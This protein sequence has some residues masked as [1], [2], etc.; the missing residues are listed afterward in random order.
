MGARSTSIA[1]LAASWAVL[2]EG[3]GGRSVHTD[4]FVAARAPHPVFNN[5]LL[6]RP[7]P[8]AVDMIENFYGH[9]ETWALWTGESATDE[10]AEAAG[11]RRDVSTTDMWRPLHDLPPVLG[12]IAVEHAAPG[13]VAAINGLSSD[14][15]PDHEAFTALAAEGD[16][17][18]LLLFRHGDDVQ[19]SFVA[20]RPTERRRGVASALVAAAL[21][22]AQRQGAATAT[23]QATPEAVSLYRRVGFEVVGRWQ[24][25]AATAP[26]VTNNGSPVSSRS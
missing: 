3:T 19:L 2:A 11:L 24:E 26:P 7:D 6:L 21:H 15:V 10:V 5:A 1:T 4:A 13:L 17:G 8:T 18:G 9:D 23:L 22:E 12:D 20:V 25:W 16:A 14:V